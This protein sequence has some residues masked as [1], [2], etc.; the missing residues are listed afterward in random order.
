[1][2][3]FI[4]STALL[5]IAIL[6]TVS[7]CSCSNSDDDSDSTTPTNK[8]SYYQV[9]Y[10]VQLS[11][12]YYQFFDIEMKYTNKNGDEATITL[13][14]NK[15][16]SLEMEYKNKPSQLTCK[17]TAKPKSN[18]STIEEGKNYIMEKNCSAQ[19][20]V[21]FQDKTVDKT[22]GGKFYN[23]PSSTTIPAANMSDYIQKE[24]LIFSYSVTTPT[25][26]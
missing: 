14:E 19:D 3:K 17:I 11:A 2:K 8:R 12:T 23:N 25:G 18:A 1:M 5:L 20:Y 24:H 10:N 16:Y 15:K 22:Y 4:L 21:Y 9:I 26:E 7:V 6:G 13:T